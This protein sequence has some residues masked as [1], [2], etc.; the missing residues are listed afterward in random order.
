MSKTGWYI[1]NVKART[2]QTSLH[3]VEVIRKLK[4][5]D[6]LVMVTKDKCI[7]LWSIEESTESTN[8][9]P[10]WI[11]I[12]LI[13][14]TLIDPTKFYNRRSK[15]DLE[16]QWDSDVVANKKEAELVFIPSC[17]KLATK[18]NSKITLNYVLK[19]FSEGL[20]KVEPETFDVN[21]VVSK[22][23]I[24]KIKT[25]HAVVRL[26]AN[27]SFSNPGHTD[28]FAQ[29]LDAKFRETN[30]DEASVELIGSKTTP[31]GNEPDGLISALTDMAEQDGTIEATI[32]SE[33]G[34]IYEK[35]NS[36]SYPR[37]VSVL[38]NRANAIWSSVYNA[39]KDIFSNHD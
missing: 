37:V 26:K 38:Q 15:E 9:I 28:M 33:E 25:A 5:Q 35:V 39:V 31:L 34:G 1:L 3:Y 2:N 14:Y 24:N 8:G 23:L 20:N 7:S 27:I 16:L 22:D 12:K 6:P 36:S 18:K 30:P 13:S 10:S 11:V 17:H 4:E 19:Y 21:I 32:Q 29:V